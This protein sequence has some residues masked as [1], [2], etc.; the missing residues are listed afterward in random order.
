MAL[1]TAADQA[2]YFPSVLL[3]GAALDMA[4]A[5]VQGLVESAIKRPLER[6]QYSEVKTLSQSMGSCRLLFTPLVLSPAPIVEGRCGSGLSRTYRPMF[7]SDW[8]AIGLSDFL[9]D[10]SG[11]FEL[12]SRLSYPITQI[13]V[14][15]FSGVDP[16]VDSPE[17]RRLKSA[18]GAALTY[19]QSDLFSGIASRSVDKEYT[20]NYGNTCAGSGILPNAFIAPFSRYKPGSY[21]PIID[22]LDP[23]DPLTPMNSAEI[24]V[25]CYAG[26]PVYVKNN[27][28]LGLA[29]ADAI[30]TVQVAGLTIASAMAAVSVEFAF[31][32]TLDL[33]DWT[34]VIGL[35]YLTPGE[36]Y[37]LSATD[38][39]KLTAVVA[40]A[41]GEYVV[42]IGTALTPTRFSIEIEPPIAL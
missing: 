7:A 15:Y 25:P 10:R 28:H 19:S 24:D 34:Q 42:R 14:S 20:V 1:L 30:A 23:H 40:N 2:L 13:R 16:L 4:I 26:Q 27:G 12:K 5:A 33:L 9:V 8:E 31:N 38:E 39:G 11:R 29:Q 6:R 17:L 18:L 22:A 41:S 37:Y 21:Q 3:T 36:V 32:G 35:Q